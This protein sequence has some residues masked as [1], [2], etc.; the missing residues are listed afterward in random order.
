MGNHQSP[1]KAS[2]RDRHRTKSDDAYIFAIQNQV[3]LDWEHRVERQAELSEDTRRETIDKLKETHQ[4]FPIRISEKVYIS[5]A[6]GASNIEN[7]KAQGVT[8]VLNVG[9]R[10]AAWRPP[11]AY[12]E[13]GINYK[14]VEAVDEPSYDMLDLHLDECLDFIHPDTTKPK[15]AKCVVHCQAGCNRSGVIVAAEH[16]LRTR[17]NVLETVLHC[18]KCR[19]N[20]FLTNPGF[21]SQLVALARKERLLGPAPGTKNCVVEQWLWRKVQ[22]EIAR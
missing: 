12:H 10:T 16:M 6:V 2:G 18:P 13:A 8:H 9:G 7:L 19:G 4:Q 20:A 3:F 14:M 22:R 11:E 21:Q 17:M 1:C 5:N 15:V